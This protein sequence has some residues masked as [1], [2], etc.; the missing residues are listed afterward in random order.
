MLFMRT[1]IYGVLLWHGRR[2][3]HVGS[4]WFQQLL[5]QPWK[6]HSVA[7]KAHIDICS[8]LMTSG[9]GEIKHESLVQLSTVFPHQSLPFLGTHS[10]PICIWLEKMSGYQKERGEEQSRLER[11]RITVRMHFRREHAMYQRQMTQNND[12]QGT[13]AKL[14]LKSRFIIVHVYMFIQTKID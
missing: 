11:W 3:D 2:R 9:I 6:P 5:I 10:S 1:Y 8:P 12:T 14:K 4:R 7:C 13:C